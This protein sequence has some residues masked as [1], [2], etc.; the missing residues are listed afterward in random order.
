MTDT[1]EP[2]EP[3]QTPLPIYQGLLDELDQA[4]RDT[5]VAALG[6]QQDGRPPSAEH[7]DGDQP[8]PSTSPLRGNVGNDDSE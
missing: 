8:R 1:R 7:R 2:D 4:S 5:V 3:L 6:S